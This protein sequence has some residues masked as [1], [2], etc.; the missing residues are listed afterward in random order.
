MW[1]NRQMSFMS[2]WFVIRN[3][4]NAIFDKTQKYTYIIIP[5][6]AAADT[7]TEAKT[8]KWF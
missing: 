4:F 2:T 5:E 6:T 1:N 7:Q 8:K 3:G